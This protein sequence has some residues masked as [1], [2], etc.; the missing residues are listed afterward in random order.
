MHTLLYLC[1]INRMILMASFFIFI[2]ILALVLHIGIT[3]YKPKAE[4]KQHQINKN[5]II[6]PNEQK[7]T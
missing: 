3:F 1:Q 7:I 5:Q 6:K 2:Y 4:Y